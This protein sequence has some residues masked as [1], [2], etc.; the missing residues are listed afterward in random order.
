MCSPSSARGTG[1]LQLEHL[2][3]G[4]IWDM[5]PA[6]GW[7]GEDMSIEGKERVEPCT[8]SAVPVRNVAAS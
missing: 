1:R 8:T 4:S 5:R 6:G 7:D 3:E 2:T